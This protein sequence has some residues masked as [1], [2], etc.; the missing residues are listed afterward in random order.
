M[1]IY[2][3]ILKYYLSSDTY[4][5][6]FIPYFFELYEHSGECFNEGKTYYFQSKLMKECTQ[7]ELRECG[8]SL[9]L[10]QELLQRYFT[11]DYTDQQLFSIIYGHWYG[12][13]KKQ[14][15]QIADKR[16]KKQ[17]W[18][19]L[20]YFMCNSKYD[21]V[22]I[23]FSELEKYRYQSEYFLTDETNSFQSIAVFENGA[24]LDLQTKITYTIPYEIFL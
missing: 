1:D 10:S 23:P 19:I 2:T 5:Q 13:T 12:L 7:R 6:S 11:S 9:T 14:L 24:F 4:F 8:F 22:L 15:S 3:K 21:T 16:H 18:S 17:A 20:N